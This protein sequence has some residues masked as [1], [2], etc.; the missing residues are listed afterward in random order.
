[1]KVG[2]WGAASP[3]EAVALL[4]AVRG[5]LAGRPGVALIAGAYADAARV[6]SGPL[7][8]AALLGAA[9][10]AGTDGVLLDTAVKDGRGLPAWLGPEALAGLVSA[11]HA[12]GQ[13]VALAGGLRLED[14][15]GVQAAGADIAGV[16]SAACR[17]GA[18]SGV[19]DKSACGPCARRARPRAPSR[20]RDHTCEPRARPA[21]P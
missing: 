7:A 10:E 6:P 3:R 15:P 2:L 1:M 11:A 18:R 19:L 17:D 9:R 12:A 21:R 8:P 5:A 16:R 20:V 13:L 14:L 4:R